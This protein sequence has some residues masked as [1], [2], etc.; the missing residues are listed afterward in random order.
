M[1]MKDNNTLGVLRALA[2]KFKLIY[3]NGASSVESV[4]NEEHR[5]HYTCL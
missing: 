4:I 1:S 5:C 2:V 3:S